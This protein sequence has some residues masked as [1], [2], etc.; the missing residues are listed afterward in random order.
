M[1]RAGALEPVLG[2][3]QIADSILELQGAK[4]ILDADL[5]RLYGVATRVLNQA[6]K[7]NAER[8][9]RDFAFRLNPDEVR[10]VTASRSQ[11]V[12]LKRGQNLKV[13]PFAFTEHGSIMAASILNSPRAVEMSVFVVRAFVRL[14]DFARGHEDLARQLAALERRVAGHDVELQRVLAALRQLLE[15]PSRPRRP[16]GFRR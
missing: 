8:F 10:R 9:P 15:P 1:T 3:Q 4:V 11:S 13:A 14:R 6:V 2:D 16:I 12:T 7:R 5:A